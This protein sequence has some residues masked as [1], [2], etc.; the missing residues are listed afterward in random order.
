M[1]KNIATES[2]SCVIVNAACAVGHIAHNQGFRSR[3][4]ACEDVRDCSG[5]YEQTFRKLESDLRR[6][7]GSDSVYC[8]RNFE[9]IVRGKECYCGVD[10][11][12]VEDLRRN[13]VQGA[14]CPTG[15]GYCRNKNI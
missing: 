10:I 15:L 1:N 4:E 13:I 5:K 8:F 14:S 2:T 6:T 7:R 9:G 12:V 3:T 11:R